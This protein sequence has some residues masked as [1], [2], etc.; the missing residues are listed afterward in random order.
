MDKYFKIANFVSVVI[1]FAISTM[2]LL[3][4][5]THPDIDGICL[6]LFFAGLI[7]AF[8]GS[9]IMVIAYK[10]LKKKEEHP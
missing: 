1:I 9:I 3:L 4:S 7:I 10:E 5:F 6:P 8:A 2:P